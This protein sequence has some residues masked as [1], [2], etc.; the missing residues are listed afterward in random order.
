MLSLFY[1]FNKK[2]ILLSNNSNI[3]PENYLINKIQKISK[4]NYLKIK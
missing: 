4:E 2:I 3:Y 1:H